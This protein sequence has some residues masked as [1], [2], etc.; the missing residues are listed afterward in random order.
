[1]ISKIICH[2]GNMFGP[3]PS[4]ENKPEYLQAALDAGYDVELDVW[5]KTDGLYLGHDEPTY[6]INRFFLQNQRVW[7]HCKNIEAYLELVKFKNI[8]CFFHTEE[9][10]VMTS[11]GFLW[12]HPKCSKFNSNTVLVKL[13]P[14]DGIFNHDDL[15]GIC[16]DYASKYMSHYTLP[17]NLLIIDIDGVM[18]DGTKMYDRDGKVFAKRYC[19]LDFTA[20]KRFLSAGIKVCFLSGDENVNKAMAETR[21]IPFFHNPAGIDKVDMLAEIKKHFSARKIAYIGDDYYD[22]SIMNAVDFPF[23]P[24]NS[25]LKVRD[26][27]SIIDV[28]AGKGVI[29]KLYDMFEEKIPYV[30]PVDSADVNPK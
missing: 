22:T 20:I 4:E 7:A 29:A 5:L 26:S 12:A 1:M 11:Q 10:M 30:F 18:T 13:D 21:K 16:T 2:R 28:E 25:P 19:D 15:Y 6:K 9:E 14:G 27:A 3:N 8:N 17:F 24:K 23:C